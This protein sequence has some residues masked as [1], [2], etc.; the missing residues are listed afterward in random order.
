MDE[1]PE[2]KMKLE[3]DQTVLDIP[4]LTNEEL[5]CVSVITITRDRRKMFP[6]AVYNWKNFF[7]PRNKLEW[8][9]VDDSKT[10]ELENDILDLLRKDFSVRYIHI[11]NPLPIADKRNYAVKQA[12]YEY[13]MNMDD[14]D[15]YF[16]DSILAKIRVAKHFKKDLVFSYPLG[17]Y[18]SL[19][20]NSAILDT[21]LKGLNIPEASMLYKKSF[22]KNNKFGCEEGKTTGESYNIM[23]KNNIDKAAKIPFIFNMIAITHKN[24]MTGSTRKIVNHDKNRFATF[25]KY[26]D[27][28]F[29]KLLDKCR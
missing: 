10:D 21:Q 23:K 19:T 17:I 5:P 22:W 18:D 26:I 27:R 16:K 24:N 8:I 4:T 1:I 14:D 25:T 28:D 13:I 6:L 11:K 15:Y 7:Y 3:K 2:A 9:I 20:G 29:R 12:K